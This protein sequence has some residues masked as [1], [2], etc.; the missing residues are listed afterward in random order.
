MQKIEAFWNQLGQH[1]DIKWYRGLFRDLE[2]MGDL[3]PSDET[4]RYI[5]DCSCFFLMDSFVFQLLGVVLFI[6]VQIL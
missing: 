1:S 3:D 2:E 6:N 5:Y 4:D